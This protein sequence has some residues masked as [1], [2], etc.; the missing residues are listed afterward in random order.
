MRR[1]LFLGKGKVKL[2]KGRSMWKTDKKKIEIKKRQL[3]VFAI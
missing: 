1:V 3:V 2:T